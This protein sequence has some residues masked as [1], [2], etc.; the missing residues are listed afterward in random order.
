MIA[1][2]MCDSVA[3]LMN[4]IHQHPFN[5][6][7]AH[8]TLPK[9]TFVHYLEQDALYL[10][11]FSKALALTAARL[12]STQH[13]Q[14]LLQFALDAVS[15][16]QEVQKTYLTQYHTM[17]S[18]VLEQYPACFM[19]TNYILS[20]A[21]LASVEEAIASLLPCFWVYREVGRNIAE[22]NHDTH[23][24]SDWITLYASESFNE[25]VNRM[26]HIT[27]ELGSCASDSIRDKMQVAFKRSTQLEWLFW[28][29]AYQKQGWRR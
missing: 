7:L 15:V 8:G 21:S 13:T 25:S 12:P 9:E 1:T 22:H 20:M 3:G 6:E 11:H 2:S 17:R 23:P 5:Q 29:G 10:A 24:Y 27:N 16:E 18:S 26:I 19:Y 14:Q 4:D 28:D